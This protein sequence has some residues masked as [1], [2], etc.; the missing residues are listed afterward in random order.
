MGDLLP[1][2]EIS[3]SIYLYVNSSLENQR[4]GSNSVHYANVLTS[5]QPCST[6]Y[7]IFLDRYIKHC[8]KL[9]SLSWLCP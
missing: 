7:E 6:H 5:K 8:T 2:G 3:L 9:Y 1:T 4:M